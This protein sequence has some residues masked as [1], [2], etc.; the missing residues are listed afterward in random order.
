MLIVGC[1]LRFNQTHI[2]NIYF[3]SSLG[4]MTEA[5]LFQQDAFSIFRGVSSGAEILMRQAHNVFA[6]Q[7]EFPNR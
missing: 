2:R 4:S 6:R 7:E 5:L 1:R 3:F